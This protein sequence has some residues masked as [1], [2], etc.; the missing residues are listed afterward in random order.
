MTRFLFFLCVIV[1]AFCEM[2]SSA[3][4][5]PSIG[6]YCKPK[7]DPILTHYGPTEAVALSCKSCHGEEC[8]HWNFNLKKT[9]EQIKHLKSICEGKSTCACSDVALTLMTEESTQEEGNTLMETV[10]SKFR[11]SKGS[12]TPENPKLDCTE[13]K[14]VIKN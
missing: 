10:Q 3:T 5:I 6:V 14:K 11:G 4:T 9:P 8:P 13:L 2:V 1:L 7:D 12:E